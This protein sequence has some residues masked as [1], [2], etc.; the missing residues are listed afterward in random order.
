MRS[1]P[2]ISFPARISSPS[3]SSSARTSACSARSGRSAGIVRAP[4]LNARASAA[5]S[6]PLATASAS[7]ALSTPIHAPRP[8]AR[9]SASG[10]TSPSGETARRSSSSRPP[11][12]PVSTQRRSGP[13]PAPRLSAMARSASG[14]LRGFRIGGLLSYGL[15]GR[16]LLVLE[17]VRAGS[18]DDL[19]ALLF[20]EP[21]LAE[22][23]ALVLR[24]RLV[25][26]Q[27][28]TGLG[29]AAARRLAL[30]GDQLVGREVGE[31]IER[32][33]PGLAENDQHL[34][35]Q[36]R[37]LGQRIV[38]AERATLGAE[39]LFLALDRL[40]G[41]VLQFLGELLVEALDRGQFRQ[42]DVGHFL[43]LGEALGDEQL[44]QRL[45]DVEL[46]LEHLRAFGE[47]ALAL[48]RGFLLGH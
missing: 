38:D 33:D 16:S 20:A 8:G 43:E 7:A 27:R 3:R 23:P 46:F 35:G 32:L 44:R 4:V 34:L 18:H 19:V 14:S 25:A 30:S 40:G 31:V 17:P 5:L 28:R 29:I 6:L 26:A 21:E 9:A 37:D 1:D 22:H 10:S 47:L 42:L 48:L 41:A 13:S 15:G 2:K 36:V 11:W 45:V 39:R 12:A 24:A